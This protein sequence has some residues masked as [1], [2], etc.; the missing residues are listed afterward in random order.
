MSEKLKKIE[1]E[2]AKVYA[3]FGFL[4]RQQEGLENELGALR[5]RIK[6]LDDQHIAES[7]KTVPAASNS[8][9]ES[10]E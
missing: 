3:R 9:T 7:A 4:K 10:G 1:E 5:L 8:A 2:A 6:E